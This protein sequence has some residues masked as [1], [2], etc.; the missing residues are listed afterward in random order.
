MELCKTDLKRKNSLWLS[1]NLSKSKNITYECRFTFPNVN[2]LIIFHSALQDYQLNC[3]YKEIYFVVNKKYCCYQCSLR[4]GAFQRFDMK[5]VNHL[6]LLG[7]QNIAHYKRN[8]EKRCNYCGLSLWCTLPISK[9]TLCKVQLYETVKNF[10]CLQND[11]DE[12]INH[13]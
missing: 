9:C 5:I 10:T 7:A 13:N 2:L 1:K 12:I 11:F 3:C 8:S 6:L 4:K